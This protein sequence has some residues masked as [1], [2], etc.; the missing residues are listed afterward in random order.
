MDEQSSIII[1]I[2]MMKTSMK[3]MNGWWMNNINHSNDLN[4]NYKAIKMDSNIIVN[5]NND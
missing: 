3:R 1:I 4:M 2:I 5:T